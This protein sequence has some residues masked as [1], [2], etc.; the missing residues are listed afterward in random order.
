M[1]YTS[2]RHIEIR[3]SHGWLAAAALLVGTLVLG[4]AGCKGRTATTTTTTSATTAPGAGGGDC[5]AIATSGPAKFEAANY[6]GH[7][8]TVLRDQHDLQACARACTANPGC[9]V[10][11]FVDAT[12]ES[13]DYRNTCVLR[14]EVGE[15]HAEQS[16]ICSWVKS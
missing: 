1:T 7:E 6:W 5:S 11:T 3:R 4:G 12:A 16:G 9:K 13:P 14:G 15:R 8:L 10:A 2:R